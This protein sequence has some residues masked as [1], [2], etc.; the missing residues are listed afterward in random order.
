MKASLSFSDWPYED[1]DA[2]NLGET[3]TFS[4]PERVDRSH[5]P[6]RHQLSPPTIW[7]AGIVAVKIYQE[8]GGKCLT[9]DDLHVAKPSACPLQSWVSTTWQ[10][11][12]LSVRSNASNLPL[13]LYSCLLGVD[14]QGGGDV[15]LAHEGWRQGGSAGAPPLCSQPIPC[16]SPCTSWCHTF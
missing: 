5:L 16:L 15:H 2:V 4:P 10:E 14:H 13:F 6:R 11:Q 9:F 12:C 8:K 7:S 3:F 1:L